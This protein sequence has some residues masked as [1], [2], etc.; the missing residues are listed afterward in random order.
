M[1][2]IGRA[3]WAVATLIASTTIAPSFADQSSPDP[4]QEITIPLNPLPF[5]L[6][7]A[8][9]RPKGDGPFPAAIIVPLCGPFFSSIEQDWGPEVTSWGYVALTLDVFSYRGMVDE[10][11]C[12]S[13]AASEV[14]EDVY[15]GLNLLIAQ[16]NVDRT[17]IFLVGFGRG[18]SVVLAAVERD[19]ASRAKHRFRG[20]AAF[21]PFC[22]DDK[23]TV[24]VST[25]VVVGARDKATFEACRKMAQGE[26]DDGIS[27]QP[28]ES[29]PIEL[30][31]LPDA[32]SGF[33]VSE[34]RT[35]RDVRGRHYEF[36]K[37]AADQSR[38]ILRRFLQ[39]VGRRDSGLH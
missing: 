6:K 24:T 27:R 9:R 14:A 19:L 32:Y 12:L 10:K 21:Y 39:S 36:D 29:A 28:G 3:A 26:D 8:L 30:A 1:K 11:T 22:R 37:A 5:D 25:L 31:A 38:E 17:R 33:D 18:G 35:P 23:G 16:R 34:F 4:P 2:R 7:G 13:F 15:R 20:A